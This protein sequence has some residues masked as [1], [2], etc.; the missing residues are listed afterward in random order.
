MLMKDINV[1][2]WMLCEYGNSPHSDENVSDISMVAFERQDRPSSAFHNEGGGGLAFP[3]PA[4]EATR[5]VNSGAD[6]AAGNSSTRL[7]LK[8]PGPDFNFS[9]KYLGGN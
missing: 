1:P 2:Y 4:R 9:A 6:L 8:A 7:P 5:G 3:R